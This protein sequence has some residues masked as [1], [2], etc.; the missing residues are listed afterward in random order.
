MM[1]MVV[2]GRT[3]HLGTDVPPLPDGE[4]YP[5]VLQSVSHSDLQALL[6]EWDPTDGTGHGSAATDWAD[7][8]QRMGYIVNLFRSRQQELHLS[9]SPFS[10]A[11][12]ATM[13]DGA[14]P[15]TI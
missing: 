8:H 2:P 7:L 13:R 1:T 9:T 5:P 14:I 11:E 3:L 12:L 10:E 4:I 15:T 6:D